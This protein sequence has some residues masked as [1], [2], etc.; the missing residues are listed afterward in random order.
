MDWCVCIDVIATEQKN[1]LLHFAAALR[2]S[3][4][5]GTP[6]V[7]VGNLGKRRVGLDSLVK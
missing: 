1:C 4:I 7:R 5:D 3:E 2:N 6:S